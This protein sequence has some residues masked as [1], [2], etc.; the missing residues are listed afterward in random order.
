MGVIYT[1]KVYFVKEGLLLSSLE[2]AYATM[3]NLRFN[4]FASFSLK[5]SVSKIYSMFL[6]SND[7]ISFA[8]VWFKS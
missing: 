3:D 7:C 2:K 1:F 8:Y 6:F 5:V 4:D